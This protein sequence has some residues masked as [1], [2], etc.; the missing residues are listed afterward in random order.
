M[1]I[2]AIYK[3]NFDGNTKFPILSCHVPAGS[4][5]FIDEYIENYIELADF[6]SN[7]ATTWLVKVSGDSMIDAGIKSGDFLLVDAS[8]EPVDGD[9]VVVSINSHSTVKRL[10][11]QTDR[12]P[13]LLA[14]NPSY[15][16][17]FIDKF[18]DFKILG[19][20]MSGIHRYR[21]F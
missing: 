7:T 13:I 14:E 21:K 16:P 18:T 4:P 15:S 8:V 11:L 6:T 19:V 17:I 3:P 2:E 1:L 9:I 12:M 20:V 10:K 5:D